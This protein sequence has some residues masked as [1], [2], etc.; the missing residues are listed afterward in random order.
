MTDFF[1]RIL[2]HPPWLICHLFPTL[3]SHLRLNYSLLPTCVQLGIEYAPVVF[4]PVGYLLLAGWQQR[5]L[6]LV[7][8]RRLLAIVPAQHQPQ[9]YRLLVL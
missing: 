1:P 8:Q 3:K 6:Q 7:Q 5:V 4:A 2:T 9:L